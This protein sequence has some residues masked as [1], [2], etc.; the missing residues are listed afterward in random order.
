MQSF[1][2]ATGSGWAFLGKVGSLVLG[3]T[4]SMLLARIIPP[5]ELGAYFLVISI[6]TV[7]TLVGQFGMNQVV[8]RFIAGS[9]ASG[10]PSKAR[11][12][13]VKSLVI[14]LAGSCCVGFLYAGTDRFVAN[15]LFETPVIATISGLVFIWIVVSALRILAAECFRGFH[16]VRMASLFEQLAYSFLFFVFILLAGFGRDWIDFYGVF[17]LS[18]IAAIISAVPA[19]W[20][21]RRKIIPLPVENGVT[22]RELLRIGCPLL[23]SNLVVVIMTQAGLWIVGVIGTSSDVALYG[24][25]Y[26]LVL[27][28]QLP[29]LI[30]NSVIPQLIAEQHAQGKKREMERLLR[31]IA[32]VVLIPTAVLFGF[33]LLWGKELLSLLFGQFYVDSY[34]VL[35]L[36]GAGIMVN[37]WTG[38]CGPALMMTGNQL[39]L[40]KISLFCGMISFLLAFYL[41]YLLGPEGVAA[42]MAFGVGGQHIL[43]VFAVKRHMGIWTFAGSMSG[44]ARRLS[45]NVS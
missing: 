38:Y 37:A 18:T 13:I 30:L 39:S 42:A 20:L 12:T 43:M 40:M 41:G 19:L 17:L 27:L 24:T 6:A 5:A 45:C 8:V 34:W 10:Q 21:L 33:F 29:L 15:E 16:D 7:A 2:L 22:A 31:L 3:L 25:A 35:I 36:L 44:L 11:D 4:T 23:V 28:L 26:R 9:I 14:V 32:T 1:R